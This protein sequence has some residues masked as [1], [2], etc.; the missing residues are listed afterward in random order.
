LILPFNRQARQVFWW[1]MVR[2]GDQQSVLGGSE[3]KKQKPRRARRLIER[4]DL[5]VLGG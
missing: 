3:V 2:G 4:M 1:V 5:G